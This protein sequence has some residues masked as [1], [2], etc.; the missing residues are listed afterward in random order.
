VVREGFAP[1]ALEA[2][3]QHLAKKMLHFDFER[4][5]YLDC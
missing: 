3:V 5:Q 2:E 1:G 4:A